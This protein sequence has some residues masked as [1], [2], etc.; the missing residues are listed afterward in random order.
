MAIEIPPFDQPHH[1]EGEVADGVGVVRAR[2]GHT[3][4]H[5]VGVADRLD[6]LQSALLD[7][8]VEL[9]EHLVEQGDQRLR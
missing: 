5:H 4:C 8:A 7:E 1:L 9:A 2:L 6:L 3:T